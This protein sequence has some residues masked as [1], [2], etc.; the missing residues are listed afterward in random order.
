MKTLEEVIETIE[1]AAQAPKSDVRDATNMG[2]GEVLHQGD[3]YL[4]RV[5]DDHPR[6]GPLGTRQVA[7]GNTVGARH[8]VKGDVEVF[9]GAQYPEGFNEPE[10][11]QPGALLG[12]LVVFGV[13]GGTLTHPEHAHHDACG[14][15]QVTYQYNPRTMRAVVD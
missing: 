11:C 4:H 9:E 12:P 10:D 15:F 1:A 14:V 7:V 13:E 6:G 2:V 5:P 8:I 3:V